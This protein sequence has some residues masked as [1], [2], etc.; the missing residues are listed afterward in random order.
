M[1]WPSIHIVAASWLVLTLLACGG[2]VAHLRTL[3]LDDL[4][5]A[6]TWSFQCLIA[7]LFVGTPSF[8]ALL[9]L[10]LFGAIA[11]HLF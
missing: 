3:P 11:K 9:L 2:Y 7:L 10:M 8:A 5:L 1:R 6:N 4:V